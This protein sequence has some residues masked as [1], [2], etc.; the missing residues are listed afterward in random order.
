MNTFYELKQIAKRKRDNAINQA[1]REYDS[2]MEKIAELEAVLN[3]QPIRKRKNS[4]AEKGTLADLLFQLLPDDKTVT[5]TD[6]CGLIRAADP[7][8]AF[9]VPTIRTIL[10][11][12]K[13]EGVIK[14]VSDAGGKRRASRCLMSNANRSKRCSSGRV[15][16]RIGIARNRG[17]RQRRPAA[18]DQ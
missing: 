14:Q 15:A 2:A 9:T 1:R 8:R 17:R 13:H 16:D 12:M 4:R 11:R 6:V 7:D 10:N 3:N 5:V 18:M